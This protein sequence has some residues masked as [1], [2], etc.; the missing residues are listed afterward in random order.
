MELISDIL[1]VDFETGRIML[2]SELKV[3]PRFELGAGVGF[4]KSIDGWRFG[5]SRT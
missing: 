5:R 4:S 2:N 3:T 1:R